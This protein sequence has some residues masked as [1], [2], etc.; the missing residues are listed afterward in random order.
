MF[1]ELVEKYSVYVMDSYNCP[2]LYEK[3]CNCK[4][5]PFL[6]FAKE[7]CKNSKSD[8]LSKSMLFE[9]INFLENNG[10]AWTEREDFK[11]YKLFYA[12]KHDSDYVAEVMNIS[13]RAVFSRIET[14]NKVF[15]LLL[16]QALETYCKLK[17]NDI[18]YIEPYQEP[19][20][21][22]FKMCEDG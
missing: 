3:V 13:E 18:S 6:K 10:G 12:D 20:I 15:A 17:K 19:F 5:S 22:L 11:T 2:E 14:V 16:Y 4:K 9:F 1:K 7:I 21:E 8:S